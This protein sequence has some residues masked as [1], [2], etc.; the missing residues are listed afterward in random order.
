MELSIKYL[1]IPP[2]NHAGL[3]GAYWSDFLQN[4][5]FD[6]EVGLSDK[7][8]ELCHLLLNTSFA[9]I[10]TLL[11]M[12]NAFA[13]VGGFVFGFLT[14]NAVIVQDRWVQHVKERRLLLRNRGKHHCQRFICMFSIFAMVLLTFFS[15]A[16]LYDPNLDVYKK[17]EWCSYLQCFE[18]RWWD[19]DDYIAVRDSHQEDRGGQEYSARGYDAGNGESQANVKG[20]E[21][22]D[23]EM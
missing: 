21:D 14:G 7:G 6:K 5:S 18:T 8:G 2:L 4:R 17:C 19:C 22:Q 23:M 9:L 20:D 16:T 3:L 10:I 15:L 1:L 11:P 13:H 12:V